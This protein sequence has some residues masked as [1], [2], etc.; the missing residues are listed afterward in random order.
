MRWIWKC[1]WILALAGGVMPA[2]LGETARGVVYND[3]NGNGARDAGEDGLPGVPVSNGLD[4]VLTGADGAYALELDGDGEIFL[5]KPAG[6]MTPL[7]EDLL[8]TFH[9]VHR[10]NGSGDLKYPGFAPTGPLPESIDFPLRRNEEPAT[11]DAILF[12]D[13]QPR[14]IKEVDY[15]THDVFEEVAGLEAAFGVTLGDIAFNNLDVFGPLKDA[16]STIGIPW[17]SLVGNHDLNMD[18]PGEARSN[19]TFIR[20]FCPPYYAFN[21][22]AVHFL[23]LDNVAWDGDGYH[24]EL[25]ARQLEFIK[26]DLALVPDGKLLV[27]MMHIPLPAL[28]D[29]DLLFDLISDREHAFSMSAH[30]HNQRHIFMGESEGWRGAKPHHHLIQATVC[31]SWMA[32]A[33][34]ERGIPHAMMSDGG[35]NGYSIATFDGVNYSIDFRPASRPATYQMSIHTPS[36]VTAAEA[37]GT[38]VLV[39]VF[40][41]SEKSTTRM[42]IGKGDWIPMTQVQREDPNV[43]AWKEKEALLHE[44]LGRKLPKPQKTGHMWAAELPAGL[45]PGGHLITVESTDMFGKTHIGRRILRVTE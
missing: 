23:V 6:W 28:Y 37:A 8:P 45:T 39:N 29:L 13:T 3:A 24:A 21:Y 41:G 16:I 4:I 18:A 27:I 40:A 9:Y 10:P 33:I 1:G 34:D 43:V 19:E 17:Y 30:T 31:G 2:A 42:R 35:P 12:G 11:F 22:G 5:I 15:L 20:E 38:E 7:T 25:G 32:G 36:E 26:K 14:N 44:S